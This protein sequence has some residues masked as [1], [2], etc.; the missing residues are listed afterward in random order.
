[1]P[2]DAHQRF[3]SIVVPTFARP[4]S[5]RECL[6]AIL[7]LDTQGVDFEV[8]VVDDGSPRP[9]D[10]VIADFHDRIPVRLVT[11]RRTGPGAAR[12]AGAAVAAGQYL[13]FVDD[14]CRPAPDWLAVLARELKR[15]GRRLLGGRVENALSGNPY[16]EASEWITQFVYDH[17]RSNTAHEP[18]FTANNIAVAAEL[19]RAVGG[20]TTAIPSATAEDKEFCDRWRTHGLVLSH[21]PDAVVRH[22][23]DLTFAR[24][25]RQ[26]FNYGRGILAFRL[27]RR[28]RIQSRI[29]PEDVNFYAR[30]VLSPVREPAAPRRWR[31]FAL[32]VVSQLATIAGAVCEV[33]RWRYLAR[34]RA[35]SQR[36]A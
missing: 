11:Q 28:N 8:I 30:L 34:V 5:L 6:N 12:N 15:D 21:V 14:D 29:V 13:V 31:V 20:F 27:L 26:H 16:S 10:R 19:F 2:A 4:D 1:L 33:T 35:T 7:D 3:I 32:L 17:N 9:L 25:V 24:F 23:H 18:F 36:K 22:A